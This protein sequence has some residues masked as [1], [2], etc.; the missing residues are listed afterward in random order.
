MLN[1]ENY[2]WNVYLEE[3]HL[4]QAA[5]NR[6]R[7]VIFVGAG[8]SIPSGMPSWSKAVEK[9]REHLGDKNYEEDF[10]KV[11]QYYYNE[12]GK[13]NYVELMREIFKYGKNLYPRDIHHKILKFRTKYIITTNYDHLLEQTLSEENQV[14]DL[15]SHDKDLSYGTAEEKL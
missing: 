6:N 9:I 5:A 1:K 8:V 15:V 3:Q 11:P 13:N 2:N 7:L 10:L 14:F 12:H 4:I